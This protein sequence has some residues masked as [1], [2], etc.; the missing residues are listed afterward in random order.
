MFIKTRTIVNII[1]SKVYSHS[2]VADLQTPIDK[3]LQARK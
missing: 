1:F 2:I 3:E